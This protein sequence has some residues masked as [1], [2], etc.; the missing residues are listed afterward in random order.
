MQCCCESQ[1]SSNDLV[2][3][4]SN[5][6]RTN[7]GEVL[8]TGATAAA[9]CSTTGSP[10][11]LRKDENAQHHPHKPQDKGRSRP[12]MQDQTNFQTVLR[13]VSDVMN[14]R[15]K[16]HQLDR[17]SR[18]CCP[19]WPCKIQPDMLQ[20]ATT[21]MKHIS[22]RYRHR[23]MRRRCRMQSLKHQELSTQR[24]RSTDPGHNPQ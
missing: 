19:L 4:N 16:V 17:E 1:P 12:M 3:L 6:T 11:A 21:V 24:T 18:R 9:V 14:T 7:D 15:Q 8:L 22:R 2:S 5:S 20:Q 23:R 10:T 13:E